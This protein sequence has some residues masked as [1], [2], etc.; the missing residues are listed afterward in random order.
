MRAEKFFNS[1]Q[2]GERTWPRCRTTT[3][4]CLRAMAGRAEGFGRFA[5]GGLHGPLYTVTTLAGIRLITL[6]N[7]FIQLF[8]GFTYSIISLL[9][10]NDSPFFES[11]LLM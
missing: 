5:I 8:K 9:S 6:K 4:L 3:D 10:P 2:T 1:T 7:L 11:N